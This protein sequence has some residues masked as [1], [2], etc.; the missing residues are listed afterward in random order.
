[1][2]P[3][4][5][6]YVTTL[7]EEAWASLPVAERALHVARGLDDVREYG[8]NAGTWVGR[9]L[10]AVGLPTG[11]SWCAAFAYY[12]LI[13]AGADPAELP[14]KRKAAGVVNWYRWAE[15]KGRLFMA[16]LRGRLGFWL[17][18]GKGHIW[19][20]LAGRS[21]DGRFPTLEGNTNARGSREGDGVHDKVRSMT[22]LA[23]HQT[24]GF[25]DLGGIG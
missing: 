6:S 5:P 19:F 24:A 3:R 14:P 8:T 15:K 17:D 10:H 18:G 4:K 13:V 9:F 12:C 7:D 23:K 2:T 22:E 16:P 25:I 11:Y 21:K 20:N 1:M